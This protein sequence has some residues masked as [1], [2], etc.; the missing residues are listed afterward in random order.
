MSDKIKFLGTGWGFPPTF[1]RSPEKVHMVSEKEDIWESIFILLSTTPGE[2][3]MQP[4][5]GCN[6]K[7]LAFEINDT[8]L[9][10]TFNHIIYHA[11]LNFEPR[12]NFIEAKIIERD[13][14]DG[15]LYIE[16]SYTIITTNTRHNIVFPFYLD[17]GTNVNF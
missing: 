14:L 8:T 10:A 5:Y 17:Q 7:R 6:L 9:M 13:E 16:I 11:L 15:V 1:S 3:I 2:R 12:V 4:E